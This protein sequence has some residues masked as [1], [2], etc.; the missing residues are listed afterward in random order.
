VLLQLMGTF[1]IPQI[2]FSSRKSLINVK[3]TFVGVNFTLKKKFD[4]C[5]SNFF[6]LQEKW[7]RY[8]ES[9]MRNH[10]CN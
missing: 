9:G 10:P 1:S 6:C 4:L 7:K 2:F 8:K 5:L 3:W